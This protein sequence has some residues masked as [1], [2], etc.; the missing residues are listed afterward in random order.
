MLKC[1]LGRLSP[2]SGTIHVFGK[3]PGSPECQIPGAGVGYMP[4]DLGLLLGFT[5]EEVITYFGKLYAM[6]G[7]EIKGKISQL[8]ELL[9]LPCSNKQIGN[10]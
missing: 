6:N 2:K 9:K 10:H 5:V 1:I 4:Q 8:L 7:R 3:T